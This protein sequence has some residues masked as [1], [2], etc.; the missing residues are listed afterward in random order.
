M[1]E[2]WEVLFTKTENLMQENLNKRPFVYI[3]TLGNAPPVITLALDRLL[4]K[5]A[6]AEV[7]IIHTDNT[8]QPERAKKGLLTMHETVKQLDREFRQASQPKEAQGEIRWQADYFDGKQWHDFTYRRVLIERE[9]PQPSKLEPAY[10]PVRDVET[11]ENSRAT[12]R[13]IYRV[14][15]R[16]KEQRAVI[17]LNIAGGRKSMSVF[18]MSSAQ[19]LFWPDDSVWHVV[20]QD[21]FMNTQAMHDD[22]G[23][24]VLV[25]IPV[26]RLSAAS[27]ALGMLLTSSDP[28]DALAAQE[29]YLNLMDVRRKDELLRYLDADERQILVGVAQGLPNEEIGVRLNKA[30]KPKTVANKL[31]DIYAELFAS[32]LPSDVEPN[33]NETNIRAFLASEFGAYFRHKGEW[34]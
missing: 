8:P 17:H 26:I 4:K 21:E 25:P 9:E 32:D 12:F 3:A 10:H 33:T 20:S 6:F 19:L 28:Y 14:L 1:K 29:N 24:S 27:P 5:H 11:E 13:T 34:L 23:Q 31:T 7:C 15:K 30:L 18:G 16:Y 22:S 2:R